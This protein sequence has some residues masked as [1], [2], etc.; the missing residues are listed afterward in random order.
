MASVQELVL[1]D[2]RRAGRVVAAFSQSAS[3]PMT[4]GNWYPKGFC[5]GLTLR[6]LAMRAKGEPWPLD[7]SGRDA[8]SLIWKA[9]GDYER[10]LYG[11]SEGL[12]GPTKLAN[13]LNKA[14]AAFG[15]R[16]DDGVDQIDWTSNMTGTEF[17]RRIVSRSTGLWYVSLQGDKGGHANGLHVLP[18]QYAKT[19][20]FDPN[21]GHLAFANGE[22][23]AGFF[24]GTVLSAYRQALSA[25]FTWGAAVRL[26]PPQV[27][28]P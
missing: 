21:Y 24:G 3:P 11:F 25:N 15:M 18:A 7:Q 9:A 4:S 13:G 28:K 16:V 1:S 14:L 17:F 20:L 2:A 27:G 22:E 8:I 12:T 23:C 26:V 5:A 10:Y 6:W 19:H